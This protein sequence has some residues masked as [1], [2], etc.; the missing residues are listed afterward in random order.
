MKVAIITSVSANIA[1]MAALTVPNKLEYCLRHGYTLIVDNQPYEQAVEGVGK[2]AAYFDTFD[3]LWALDADA[4]ITNMARRIEDVPGLGPDVTVCKEQMVSWNRVNCGSV[5][6][7]NTQP[8]RCLM[9][10]IS[11]DAASWRQLPCGWQT[12]F[13]D[14]HYEHAAVITAVPS[15]TFN[16]VEWTHP[17]G[18]SGEPGSNWA[19][20][21]FVYHPCG[22][23]PHDEKLRRI[24]LKLHEV[25]R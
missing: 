8:S 23:F 17:G 10:S 16:S 1:A 19:P 6:Y 7:R 3:L 13:G 24:A 18:A 22:V 4:I 15:R 2:L 5:I 14:S 9:Q 25:V 20:G 11:N 21:D 12:L